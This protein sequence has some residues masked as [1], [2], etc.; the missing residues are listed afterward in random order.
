MRPTPNDAASLGHVAKASAIRARSWLASLFASG[1]L[2]GVAAQ[3]AEWEPIFPGS[4][5]L[6]DAR[7]ELARRP[8]PPTPK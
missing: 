2:D 4:P 7:E 5:D 8:P 1:D 3:L 6:V